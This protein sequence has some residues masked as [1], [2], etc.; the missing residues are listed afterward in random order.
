MRVAPGKVAVRP[1]H[2][3]SDGG[4]LLAD[5]RRVTRGE[6]YAIGKPQPGMYNF[7]EMLKYHLFGIHPCP[8]KVGDKVIVPKIGNEVE[9]VMVFWQSEINVYG[10]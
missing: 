9:G 6:V 10:L 8:F 3:D 2:Q 1:F 7:F 4:V 5:S